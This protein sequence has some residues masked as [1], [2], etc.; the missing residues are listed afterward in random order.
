MWLGELSTTT[1]QLPLTWL[2]RRYF[3]DVDVV[4]ISRIDDARNTDGRR[5]ETCCATLSSLFGLQVGVFFFRNAS[6]HGIRIVTTA[7]FVC[8]VSLGIHP[9]LVGRSSFLSDIAS[10]IG[11]Q[12]ASSPLCLV[13]SSYR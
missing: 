5:R 2:L 12:N 4:R 1:R 7:V 8:A 6:D 3:E 13:R 9:K 10:F 11:F